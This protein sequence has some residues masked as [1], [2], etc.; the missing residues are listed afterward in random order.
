MTLSPRQDQ[1]IGT[2]QTLTAMNTQ[3]TSSDS[4]HLP[5]IAGVPT[6][7]LDWGIFVTIDT[8]ENQYDYEY[9]PSFRMEM[10]PKHEVY[11]TRTG[12]IAA[13]LDEIIA[14][15]EEHVHLGGLL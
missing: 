14:S 8:P 9:A 5:V 7:A 12:Q 2:G 11:V 4:V 1:P 13:A 3:Q 6:S 15:F 10:V